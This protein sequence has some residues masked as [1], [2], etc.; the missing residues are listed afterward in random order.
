MAKQVVI[1][2]HCSDH[3]LRW[4][5]TLRHEIGCDFNPANKGCWT[6]S[7]HMESSY[8]AENHIPEEED[9]LHC[10]HWVRE[11]ELDFDSG[12]ENAL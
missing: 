4:E 1:C 10:N 3:F 6:C 5:D 11:K 2:G 12:Y 8:C 7:K 9:C